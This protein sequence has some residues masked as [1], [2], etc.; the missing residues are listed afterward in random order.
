MRSGWLWVCLCAAPIA[1]QAESVR[2]TLD[3]EHTYPSFEADHLG[4]ST[5]RGKFERSR[6]TLQL[7]RTAGSGSVEVEVDIASIAFGLESMDAKARSAELFDVA[8]F[9]VA[10]FVARLEGF[11]AG[12]P[13]RA[14]GT[15]SLHGV[16]QPLTLKIDSLRCIPH[17]LHQRELCGADLSGTLQ[18]DAF[19]IDA[20][21]DYGFDM[22]VTLRI[23]AEALRDAEA[24]AP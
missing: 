11:A 7:D 2:Y 1:A 23:Q 5:W 4:I 20:G 9:P 16:E 13:A 10:R 18:R 12:T 15:L 21:K 3:P 24:A 6:G 22:A 8:R 19:G 14:V 17:P